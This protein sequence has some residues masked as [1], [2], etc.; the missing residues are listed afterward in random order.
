MA[1][2]TMT[3]PPPGIPLLDT[4]L[5][6]VAPTGGAENTGAAI[7]A[8]APPPPPMTNQEGPACAN[9]AP[10][11]PPVARVGVFHP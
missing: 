6:G 3:I 11:N 1:A 8:P 2:V 9:I 5:P 7:R 10:G 4:P